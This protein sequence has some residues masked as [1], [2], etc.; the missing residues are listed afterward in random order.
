MTSH[1]S[2]EGADRARASTYFPI[3]VHVIVVNALVIEELL[4]ATAALDDGERDRVC[5]LILMRPT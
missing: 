4:I 5:H 2:T 3:R 1:E